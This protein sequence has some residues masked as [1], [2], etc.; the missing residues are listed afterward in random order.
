MAPELCQSE[1]VCCGE[2]YPD[3]ALDP[4]PPDL[5]YPGEDDVT[6][7]CPA[8]GRKCVSI[9]EPIEVPTCRFS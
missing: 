4:I 5:I 1:C 3:D 6:G 7:I 2:V 8:C 9:P